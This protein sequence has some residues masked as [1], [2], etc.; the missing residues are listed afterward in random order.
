MK[1]D[2]ESGRNPRVSAKGKLE[3]MLNAL[4]TT[5]EQSDVLGWEENADKARV[6]QNPIKTR[7][8]FYVICISIV[9]II[10]WSAY[11][12]IDQ[13][14]RGEGKVIPSQK[15]QILQSLD[16]GVI[17]DIKV[18]EGQV[19]EKN[20][21]IVKLDATRFVSNFQES[22][23]EWL[24]LKAKSVRLEALA[25]G[26]DFKISDELMEEAPDL[27]NQETILYHS[28]LKEL[29]VLKEIAVQQIEQREQELVE[30]R[31]HRDQAEK[32][33][34]L[35]S[36][37]LEVTKPL[38]ESGAV[39]EVEILRLERDVANMMGE[40]DQA[41]AQINRLIS[42]KLEARQKILEVELNFK[43]EIRED[44]SLTMARLNAL[45]KSS[46]GLSDRVN[47]TS[48]RSPVRGTVKRLFYN[49]IGGVVLPGKE[50]VEIIPLDDTLLLEARIKPQ[51]IA[52]LRP[53][54]KANVKFTAYDFVVYGGL[55]A[56][57]EHIGVDT[58]MDDNG[59]PFYVVQ[60]RTTESDLGEGKP[61]IPG[62]VASVDIMTGKKTILTYI[63]KPLLRA[64]QYALTER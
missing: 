15:V 25:E 39:S 1:D 34:K 64:K 48:V 55:E 6:A 43:N 30:A 37:E 63:L 44:L 2:N 57:I 8:I 45:G 5:E 36:R 41:L 51:D 50:V 56:Q 52:F 27:V 61:I 3:G 54:Q 17:T 53:E 49:T 32:A 20:Q 13:V 47:Q 18:R 59:N 46:L 9:A 60:V 14:T 21:L 38:V 35:S 33:L 62:M 16:G 28:S 40:R 29:E 12:E 4:D 11:A 22:R 31:S 7:L 58:V 24:A 19:V 10:V 23:A 42:A 26:T